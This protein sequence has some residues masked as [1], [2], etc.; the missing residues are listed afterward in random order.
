MQLKHQSDLCQKKVLS[1]L[2][3][4]Q[5]STNSR[6]LQLRQ[7]IRKAGWKNVRISVKTTILSLE[8]TCRKN[9]QNVLMTWKQDLTKHKLNTFGH[10]ARQLVRARSKCP[11]VREALSE[12]AGLF[13]WRK[14]RCVFQTDFINNK[15]RISLFLK[16][17]LFR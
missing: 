10:W 6:F 5:M 11:E 17:I 1:T 13:V 16:Q 14:Y 9:L 8:S 15:S 12:M 7:L 4:L 2:T 3:D